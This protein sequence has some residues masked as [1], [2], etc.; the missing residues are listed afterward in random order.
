MLFSL[1]EQVSHFPFKTPVIPGIHVIYREELP[2]IISAWQVWL[3][4]WRKQ[5]GE[6]TQQSP[7]FTEDKQT[8]ENAPVFCP[9][10]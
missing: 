1:E 4:K 6:K 9:L 10:I 5:H 2:H 3:K 8:L 7:S